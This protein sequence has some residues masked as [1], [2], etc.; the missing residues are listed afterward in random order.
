MATV[1]CFTPLRCVGVSTGSSQVTV[2]LDGG[3]TWRAHRGPT[4]AQLGFTSLSCDR[5]GDCLATAALGTMLPAGALVAASVDG[6]VHWREILVRRA[7]GNL[8][9]RFN[10]VLCSTRA[11]CLV[12]GTDGTRGFILVTTNA[13]RTWQSARLPNQPAEGS[14]A[15]VACPSDVECLATQATRAQVY[16]SLDAGR[17]WTVLSVPAPFARVLSEKGVV[18]GLTALSCGSSTFCVAGGYIAHTQLQST[19]EPFKWVTTDAGRTWRFDPPFAVTGAKS[20]A[21]ISTGAIACVSD[22]ACILGLSYGDVYATSDAGAT[23]VRD[24]GAPALDSNILSLTCPSLPRCVASVISN[25]PSGQLLK[26][27]IWVRR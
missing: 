14:I 16:R 10:D 19:T 18:T 24:R 21:A 15:A 7:P 6:G 22:T 13:G 5:A 26:G 11:R 17:T 12:T 3:R 8:R 27:S 4:F 23:W 20:P 2:S 1:D 9:Y 25:F